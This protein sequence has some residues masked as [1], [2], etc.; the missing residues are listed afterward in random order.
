MSRPSILLQPEE[1]LG[2]AQQPRLRV[3]QEPPEGQGR[4]AAEQQVPQHQ[5]NQ[6]LSLP[7]FSSVLTLSLERS[8]P[9]GEGFRPTRPPH[10]N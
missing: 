4:E 3:V 2:P 10:F 7:P 5:G 6:A 9:R 1:A 8:D